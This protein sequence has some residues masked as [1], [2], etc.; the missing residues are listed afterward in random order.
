[1]MIVW[2]LAAMVPAATVTAGL[3]SAAVRWCVR[4]FRRVECRLTFVAIQSRVAI[5]RP[6]LGVPGRHAKPTCRSAMPTA[7]EYQCQQW[8]LT[9][10]RNEQPFTQRV[11]DL[12]RR[13]GVKNMEVGFSPEVAEISQKYLVRN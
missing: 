9:V 6:A 5:G 2:R 7:P 4:R 3:I 1:M 8:L 11:F 10:G 13:T 12:D